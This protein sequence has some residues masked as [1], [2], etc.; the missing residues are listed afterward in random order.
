MYD[1]QAGST[2]RTGMFSR[3]QSTDLLR[4]LFEVEQG[5]HIHL[6]KEPLSCYLI[7]FPFLV[8]LN[9]KTMSDKVILTQ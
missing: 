6:T 9:N 3:Y 1:W 4:N 7:F 8:Y 2:Y 5:K